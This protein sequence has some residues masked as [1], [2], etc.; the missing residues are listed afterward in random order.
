MAD[1]FRTG[2]L[3]S[4]CLVHDSEIE[5]RFGLGHWI[6]FAVLFVGHKSL[7]AD[8]DLMG[9]ARQRKASGMV[10]D[11]H[12][13]DV[14][15]ASS[16]SSENCSDAEVSGHGHAQPRCLMIMMIPSPKSYPGLK[17]PAERVGKGRK[18][19]PLNLTPHRQEGFKSLQREETK[20]RSKW[21]KGLSF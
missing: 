1:S 18:H 3:I 17:P 13:D 15:S 9:K 16:G 8:S 2:R 20:T 5:D 11:A 10:A 6:G 12:I 4:V 21:S 14:G 7:T 19:L